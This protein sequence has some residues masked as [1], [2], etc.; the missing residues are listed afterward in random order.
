MIR[1]FVV[2]PDLQQFLAGIQSKALA[3]VVW[4][5]TFEEDA[6]L[7]PSNPSTVRRSLMFSKG[8]YTDDATPTFEY[9]AFIQ[10]LDGSSE[11]VV[12][13]PRGL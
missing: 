11:V 9:N 6:P 12:S 4:N 8:G 10:N 5:I 7:L 3:N 1:Q 13:S 2:D